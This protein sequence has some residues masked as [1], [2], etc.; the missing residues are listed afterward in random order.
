V[1]QVCVPDEKQKPEQKQND[2]SPTLSIHDRALLCPESSLDLDPVFSRQMATTCPW[3]DAYRGT[4]AYWFVWALVIDQKYDWPS[5]TFE[6][7]WTRRT[8]LFVR[9]VLRLPIGDHVDAW[10][11]LQAWYRQVRDQ[12]RHP[13]FRLPNVPALLYRLR[14]TTDNRYLRLFMVYSLYIQG[15]P[16][17]LA[18]GYR[19]TVDESGENH[20]DD[21]S[22]L[23]RQ[24]AETCG[25]T[26][27]FCALGDVKSQE[28]LSFDF[29][30]ADSPVRLH[31]AMMDLVE[32]EPG[33][34]KARRQTLLRWCRRLTQTCVFPVP[35]L[36]L[37]L[38]YGLA[39]T[40]PLPFLL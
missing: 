24:L 5:E 21:Q 8:H 29:Q 35:V 9:H 17:C 6:Q 18:A 2:N 27:L 10:P 40:C 7:E 15:A 3:S 20:L 33:L 28:R 16:L 26:R 31:R 22:D 38:E 32:A 19:T 13:E 39:F 25:V 1:P 30:H 11:I 37:V 36:V 14:A 4:T 23:V 34:Q 12:G